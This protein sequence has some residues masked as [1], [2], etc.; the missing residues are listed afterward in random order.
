MVNNNNPFQRNDSIAQR[1]VVRAK[2]G[3]SHLSSYTPEKTPIRHFL[4]FKY[5]RYFMVLNARGFEGIPNLG[6]TNEKN[7]N[8]LKMMTMQNT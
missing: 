2:K 5:R 7:R 4:K 1:N 3:T 6:K 8:P